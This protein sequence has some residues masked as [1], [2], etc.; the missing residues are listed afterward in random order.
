M[1]SQQHFDQHDR[2]HH[3]HAHF[4]HVLAGLHHLRVTH[5]ERINRLEQEREDLEVQRA[6]L[7]REFQKHADIHDVPYR[8]LE[9]YED[10][11]Y[12]VESQMESARHH[13]WGMVAGMVIAVVLGVYFSVSTLMAE[14][15]TMLF[16]G[17]VLVAVGIGKF[18]GSILTALLGT[19]AVRP[20][21]ARSLNFAIVAAGAAFFLMLTLFAWLRFQ[22]DSPLVALLPS[23]MVGM[24]LTAIVFAGACD[25][26]YRMYRWS[27]VF[28]ERHR[29]LLHREAT[30]EDQLANRHVDLLSVEHRIKEHEEAHHD[31]HHA[32]AHAHTEG[33][34]ERHHEVVH[35]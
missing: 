27:G 18:A 26:G 13:F 23:L 19:S 3:H 28:H 20:H 7:V 11:T 29:H 21:A 22:S 24:E 9:G 5:R 34:H 4:D 10:K 8:S 30:V 32:H 14:S 1:S 17:S 35:H 33:H 12:P 31:G 2:R 15:V 16:L 25:C 6:A